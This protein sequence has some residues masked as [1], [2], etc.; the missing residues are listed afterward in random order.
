[1]DIKTGKTV[2]FNSVKDA[3]E[4]IGYKCGF[5]EPIK[6]RYLVKKRYIFSYTL[7]GLMETKEA[8]DARNL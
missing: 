1:M 7:L 8:V 3:M 4:S 5:S 2:K 6:R